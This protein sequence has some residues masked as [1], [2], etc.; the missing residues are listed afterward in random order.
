MNASAPTKVCPLCAETIKAAAKVCPWCGSRQNWWAIWWY[1]YAIVVMGLVF[2]GLAF[3]IL[4]WIS[5]FGKNAGRNF[6]RHRHDLAVVKTAL[7][8]RTNLTGF[9]LT[10]LV[11]NQGRYPWRVH[12]LEVR[13][14][15]GRGALRDVRH[16]TIAEPFVVEPGRD[17]GFQ[18]YL[19]QL[20]VTNPAAALYVRVQTASD[21]A[22]PLERD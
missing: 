9:S 1:E 13:F 21:G 4:T 10:G 16:E 2:L 6:A 14:G 12:G 15:D 8:P 22:R 17:H 3:W 7:V 19:G 11:T 18:V 20:D 5:P